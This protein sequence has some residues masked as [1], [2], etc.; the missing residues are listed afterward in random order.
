MAKDTADNRGEGECRRAGVAAIRATTIG[1]ITGVVVALCAQW[2]DMGMSALWSWGAGAWLVPCR[3]L[4]VGALAGATTGWSVGFLADPRSWSRSE[5]KRWQL[6]W[7]GMGLGVIIGFLTGAALGEIGEW[8]RLGAHPDD[9]AG[10]SAPL[11]LWGSEILVWWDWTYGALA[12]AIA[13]AVVGI[14]CILVG[15]QIRPSFPTS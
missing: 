8:L 14:V 6:P 3:W 5:S 7:A 2:P 1:S 15:R 12:G 9:P 13:G 10:G 11:D 4:A